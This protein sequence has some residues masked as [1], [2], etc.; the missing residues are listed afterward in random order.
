MS[1]TNGL[2][3]VA[4]SRSSLMTEDGNSGIWAADIYNDTVIRLYGTSGTS[5]LSFVPCVG[6]SCV[7][8]NATGQT[9]ATAAIGGLYGSREVY[10]DSTGALWVM[11]TSVGTGVGGNIT[12]IFGVAAP[13]FPLL[14]AGHPAQMP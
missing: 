6:S 10:A 7:L 8:V 3:N 9:S 14:Q 11:G 1:T 12:Q 5:V 4:Y 13:S 2:I